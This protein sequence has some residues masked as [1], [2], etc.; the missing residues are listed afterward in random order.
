MYISK[1]KHTQHLFVHHHQILG[2]NGALCAVCGNSLLV[3]G[4]GYGEQRLR[5]ERKAGAAHVF[6]Q[7]GKKPRAVMSVG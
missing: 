3:H 5:K 2:F 4:I 1:Y 7:Y 6:A